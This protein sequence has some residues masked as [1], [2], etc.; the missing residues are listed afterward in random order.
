MKSSFALS[1]K[2]SDWWQPFLPYWSLIVVAEIT[3]QLT[4]TGTAWANAHPWLAV[5]IQLGTAIVLYFVCLIFNIIFLRILA[6]KLSCAGESFAF[7]GKIGEYVVLNIVGM[8]LS[9]V[10]LGV[11]LP[12]YLRRVVAYLASKTSYRGTDL[13]FLGRGGRL[14]VFI[15]LGVWAPLIALLVV[16]MVTMGT[17]ASRVMGDGGPA[18]A[19]LLTMLATFLVV[20]YILVVFVYLMY[21]WYV[22]FSWKD[23]CVR[24]KTTFW[25]SCGFVLGQVLLSVITVSVYWPAAFLKTYRYFAEKTILTRDEAEIGRLGFEGAPGRGFGLI[26]GQMLLSVITVGFYLPWAYANVGRWLIGFTYLERAER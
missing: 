6:P 8:L 14:F 17:Q 26:W 23:I 11:F 18:G 22:D 19:Q 2:G 1:L 15:L 9:L 3:L 4:R 5:L 24:W 16:I 7:Q 10:T 12:W 20:L 21:K 25:R 13:Q